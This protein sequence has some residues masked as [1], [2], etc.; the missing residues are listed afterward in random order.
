MTFF[1]NII[2]ASPIPPFTTRSYVQKNL[3]NLNNLHL[4]T[5]S[6]H[7]A[8]IRVGY[9]S[10]AD[11][12]RLFETLLSISKNGYTGLRGIII[13]QTVIMVGVFVLLN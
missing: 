10:C 3:Q 13:Y 8:H 4:N 6:V 2:N 9:N 11:N 1:F 7:T 5:H 12:T